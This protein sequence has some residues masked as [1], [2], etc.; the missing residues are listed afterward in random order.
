MIYQLPTGKIVYLSLE[1]YLNLTHEDV[2]Y[3]EEDPFDESID[4]QPDNEE[5][6]IDTTIS[7]DN[8]DNIADPD[9]I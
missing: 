3:L 7:L 5:I 2:Q 6:D 9:S 4:Y 8:L 1:E